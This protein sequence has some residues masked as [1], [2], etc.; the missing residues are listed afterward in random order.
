MMAGVVGRF[1]KLD[2]LY[3]NAGSSHGVF[4]PL[5]TLELDGW[6]RVMSTNIRRVR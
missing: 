1:G 5:H 6:E 3:K 4:G 2:I